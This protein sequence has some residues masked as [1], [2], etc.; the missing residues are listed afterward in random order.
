VK[1]R[2]AS[3]RWSADAPVRAPL[4]P[5]RPRESRVQ[6]VNPRSDPGVND[7]APPPP[8]GR[9][10]IAGPA[11]FLRRGVAAVGGR[12]TLI[13]I[14]AAWAV[15]RVVFMGLALAASPF[16]IDIA[17]LTWTHDPL[18]AA[19]TAWDGVY[20]LGIAEGGYHAAPVIAG[21]F[22]DWVFF[23]LYPLL[24][25]LVAPLF[26]G[27]LAWAGI[28]VS[29]L[30]TLVALL[31]FAAVGLRRRTPAVVRLTTWTFVFMP[32][33]CV[34]VMAYADSL[35]LAMFALGLLA[36]DAGHPR[37]AGLAYALMALSRPPGILFGIPLAFALLAA[38]RESTGRAGLTVLLPLI[39]GPLALAGF[40]AYQGLILGDPGAW[41][42]GQGAWQTLW[43]DLL[44]TPARRPLVL[45]YGLFAIVS[46]APLIFLRRIQPTAADLSTAVVGVLSVLLTGRFVSAPRYLLPVWHL[47][48]LTLGITARR[49]RTLVIIAFAI[50]GLLYAWLCFIWWLPP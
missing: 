35:L 31:A 23:P 45:A 3:G 26:R 39:A 27:D 12:R 16:M 18:T 8:A 30:A 44:A 33:A 21:T 4:W 47:P 38:R 9:S 1:A 2:T 19:L 6:P 22:P 13:S 20:Y 7:A 15:S 42:N 50:V 41:V 46:L 37:R 40:C 14:L 28:T 48:L 24:V 25:R 29:N 36:A 17:G 34:L 5:S 10:A 32:G 49:L 43:S 11:S